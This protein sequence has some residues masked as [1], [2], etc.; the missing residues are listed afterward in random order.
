ML[1]EALKIAVDAH[2]GQTDKNGEAYIL[3]SLAVMESM[4][5]EEERI[6]AILHDVI[7]DTDWTLIQLKETGFF[8][9][10]VLHA[11]WAITKKDDETYF[12]Y[13]ERLKFS[14]LAVRVKLADL[15][16][17]SRLERQFEKSE[18]L[19]KRYLKAY[20]MLTKE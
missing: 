17:N 2:Y 14:E 1:D 6:V 7:E 12:E 4:N 10:N 18:G 3:H 19:I 9:M 16:H 8:S 11:M 20:R 13:I 5:T 15:N